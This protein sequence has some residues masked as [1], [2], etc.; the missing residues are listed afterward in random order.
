MQLQDFIEKH[1]MM[2]NFL[3]KTLKHKTLNLL[4]VAGKTLFGSKSNLFAA[5][6][7]MM[8]RITI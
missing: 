2:L 8:E 4:P 5:I 7:D 6:N 1:N 3:G